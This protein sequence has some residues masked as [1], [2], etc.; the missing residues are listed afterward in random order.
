METVLFVLF[1]LVTVLLHQSTKSVTDK[2][3]LIFFKA[4]FT[5]WKNSKHGS[6]SMCFFSQNA[7][8]ETSLLQQTF[9]FNQR[10]VYYRK[11][12]H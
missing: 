1:S 5:A 11:S 7:S 12:R 6:M 8:I 3:N 2:V 4:Y 10:K 9:D